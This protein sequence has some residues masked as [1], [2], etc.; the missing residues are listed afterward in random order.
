MIYALDTNTVTFLLK[1]NEN[2]KNNADIALDNGH[3][4]IIP[5]I[6]DY[7][8]QRGLVARRMN[9]KLREYLSF[10]QFIT[11][12]A[13]SDKVWQKAVQIYAKLSQQ[14]KPIGDGDI[15]IAAFCLVN[16]Y[17][18][19]TDNARHFNRIDGLSFINWLE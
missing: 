5:K 3:N 12:G 1:E 14:G 2:V 11:I 6:V 7:E 16:E 19:V 15:L 8:I 13:I 4:L 17:V 18:L 10:C 9:K